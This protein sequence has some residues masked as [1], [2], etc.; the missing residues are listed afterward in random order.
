MEKLSEIITA[1]TCSA[2]RLN[3]LNFKKIFFKTWKKPLKMRGF[4]QM[5][6]FLFLG[7][8]VNLIIDYV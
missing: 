3:Y 2:N 8:K 5:Q 1:T 7:F 6:H 4:I